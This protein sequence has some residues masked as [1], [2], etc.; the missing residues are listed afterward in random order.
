MSQYLITSFLQKKDPN[1]PAYGKRTYN[2]LVE[3]IMAEADQQFATHEEEKLDNSEN[4]KTDDPMRIKP[5]R[6][7]KRYTNDQH[8]AILQLV[9]HM[10]YAA[11]ER[12]YGVDEST[13]RL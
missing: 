12:R 2:K 13:C 11:I 3:P 8:K 7:R 10:T 6:S 1:V 9:P 5:K 4:A